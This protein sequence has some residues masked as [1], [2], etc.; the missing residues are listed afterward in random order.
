[1]LS[2]SLAA[3]GNTALTSPFFAAALRRFV[4]QTLMDVLAGR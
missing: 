2:M 1:M 3:Q 4:S